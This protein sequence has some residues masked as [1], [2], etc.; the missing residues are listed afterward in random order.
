MADEVLTL[1]TAAN[2]VARAYRDFGAALA[3]AYAGPIQQ[4]ARAFGQPDPHRPDRVRR[5]HTEYGRRHRRG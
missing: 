4:L 5:M 2:R 3:R 1:T